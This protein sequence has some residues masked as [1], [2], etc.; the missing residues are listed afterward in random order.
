[1]RGVALDAAGTNE[2]ALFFFQQLC[3]L[4]YTQEQMDNARTWILYGDWTFKGKS[5]TVEFAD[6]FP[7]EAQLRSTSSACGFIVL[8]TQE[9]QANRQKVAIQA[10]QDAMMEFE[11]QYKPVP[12]SETERELNEIL[13]KIMQEKNELRIENQKLIN[14]VGMLR[15]KLADK[16]IDEKKK[17]DELI[18][19]VKKRR[20]EFHSAKSLLQTMKVA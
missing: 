7:T 10:R 16:R 6:F 19:G 9:W 1:M 14:E 17:E 4:G 20:A 2:R 11:R 15:A 8:S 13:K 5:P 12:P 3:A 18:D